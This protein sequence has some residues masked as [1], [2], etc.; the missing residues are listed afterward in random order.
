[1]NYGGLRTPYRFHRPLI[2]GI[3]RG[4]LYRSFDEFSSICNGGIRSLD[5]FLLF[6]LF[7]LSI[8]LS[9]PSI[10]SLF[11]SLLSLLLSL[12]L[13]VSDSL[14]YSLYLSL[15]LYTPFSLSHSFSDSL[16]LSVF[17][18]LA[19]Y[20]YHSL[21]HCQSFY[22][23]ICLSIISVCL[24]VCLYLSLSSLHSSI[25]SNTFPQILPWTYLEEVLRG[26]KPSQEWFTL[27]NA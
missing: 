19:L 8:F 5:S 22:L 18:S 25:A 9:P 24:S 1:M 20:F 27:I 7:S 23:S 21:P 17:V 13:S 10:P 6:L 2:V 14:C 11:P 4:G 12:V 3:N 16:C 26:F 15:L